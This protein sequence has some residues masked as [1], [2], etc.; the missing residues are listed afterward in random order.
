LSAVPS[1]LAE[2]PAPIL[3]GQPIGM[4]A[5]GNPDVGAVQ[6]VALDPGNAGIAYLAA[7]NGGI[8]KA[9]DATASNLQPQWT[10]V[11][12][13]LP[14]QAIGDISISPLDSKVIYAG[15]GNFTNGSFGSFGVDNG[16]D[17]VG[18]YRSGDSGQSWQVLGDSTFKGFVIRRILP[19][20]LTTNQGQVVLAA[21]PRPGVPTPGK[22]GLGLYMSLDSGQTWTSPA[23]SGLP[24]GSINDVEE[25]PTDATR[26]F[27]GIFRS[28]NASANGIYVGSFASATKTITWTQMNGRGSNLIPPSVLAD[29]N[30]ALNNLKISVVNNSGSP[31]VYVL[32]AQPGVAPPGERPPG[33]SHVYVSKDAGANWTNI[34]FPA[35]VA[36]HGI[37]SDDEEPNV[38][39][40]AADPQSPFNVFIT[41][42]SG[43][44]PGFGSRSL[45]LG[46]TVTSSLVAT[47]SPAV[48]HQ[49]SDTIA[50]SDSRTLAFD[51]DGNLVLTDDGGIYRL[52]HPLAADNARAWVSLIGNLNST[53]LYSVAYDQIDHVILGG[54]QDNGSMVQTAQ[55][56]QV[57][58]TATGDDVTHVAVDNSGAQAQLY[59]MSE[60]FDLFTRATFNGS[61]PPGRIAIALA[62][63]QG[64]GPLSGLLPAD[65]AATMGAYIPFALNA[66]KPRW[67]ALGL[68]GLYESMNQGDNVTNITPTAMTSGFLSALA[69]GGTSGGV[70]NPHVLYAAVNLNQKDPGPSELF[71]R[72]GVGS[73]YLT[74][75]NFSDTIRSITLDPSDWHTAYLVLRN[76]ILR[77]SGAG[78]PGMTIT[79]ITGN[80]GSLAEKFQSVLVY[81]PTSTPGAEIVLIG[82]LPSS[83]TTGGVFVTTNPYAGANTSWT[84]FGTGLPNVQA[85][86]LQYNVQDN[87]LVAGTF[88]RGAWAI[89]QASAFLP[90]TSRPTSQTSL[91]TTPNPAGLG[92]P[93][94]FSAH[95]AAVGTGSGSPTG[96]VTFLDGTVVLGTAPLGAGGVA[97]FTTSGLGLGNH[98]SSAVYSG[99]SVFLA[100]TSGVV[101]EVIDPAA[102]VVMSLQRTGVHLQ[103]TLL[104][105]SFSTPLDAASAQNLNNYLLVQMVPGRPGRPSR[106]LA[107]KLKAAVYNPILQTVTLVPRVRLNLR[108]I[109]RLTVVGTAPNGVRSATGQLLDGNNNGQPGSNYQALILGFGAVPIGPLR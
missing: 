91:I 42:S 70:A 29:P 3:N 61:N 94:T 25:D 17:A 81:N 23:S 107:I 62:D 32:T 20:A 64:D 104:V 46:A 72:T 67:L 10:F 51:H 9:T 97:T 73:S 19:T 48:G 103:P 27:A 13:G 53:E 43:P 92:Q 60:G 12:G 21:V 35:S 58:I 85:H 66:V 89:N 95:V 28:S 33:V 55:G 7:V 57:S 79:N 63:N 18:V 98:A 99:D 6:A 83:G 102:P 16:G 41:G 87:I 90:P 106:P 36:P 39:A 75:G 15:T 26:F 71:L 5:Q 77:I 14:S 31:L 65:Q 84:S 34:D 105:L 38:L 101:S 54:A 82:A 11:S 86:D 80:L 88:G 69:Y 100:S 108:Q 37:N 40:I 50:H 76:T 22:H 59:A 56:S 74:I 45:V 47:W 52:L 68:N 8:W 109:Y 78:T 30:F 2:G 24:D 4:D 44:T 1:W 93:V 96:T 49:A